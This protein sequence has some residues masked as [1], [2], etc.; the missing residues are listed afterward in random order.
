MLKKFIFTLSVSSLLSLSSV[1]AGLEDDFNSSMDQWQDTYPVLQ[2][3][4]NHAP[5]R[6]IQTVT[7]PLVEKQ[8]GNSVEV[9]RNILKRYVPELIQSPEYGQ[10]GTGYHEAVE[11]L[12]PVYR[13][14]FSLEEVT[15]LLPIIS[16]H[17]LFK[18][19]GV[20]EHDDVPELL[21]SGV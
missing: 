5:F 6:R 4:R 8:G 20:I 16:G 12:E 11:L 17:E 21:Q 18:V 14:A 1:H 19:H 3:V 10:E 9:L 13:D 2:A 15:P 7:V